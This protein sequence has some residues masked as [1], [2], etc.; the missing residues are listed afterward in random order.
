M[1]NISPSH[2]YLVI[3][4]TGGLDIRK[5]DSPQ[6]LWA[7][8]EERFIGVIPLEDIEG[9]VESYRSGHTMELGDYQQLLGSG[10]DAPFLHGTVHRTKGDVK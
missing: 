9:W 5:A 1:N 7:M 6:E 8:E 4:Y 3:N 10:G 2:N